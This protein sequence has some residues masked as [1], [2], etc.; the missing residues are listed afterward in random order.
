MGP[1]L[2][3]LQQ[4]IACC[5]PNILAVVAQPLNLQGTP[6]S[7]STQSSMHAPVLGQILPK[8]DVRHACMLQGFQHTINEQG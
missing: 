5:L 2:Q 8:K 3:Q 4:Q 7:V 1:H 6:G